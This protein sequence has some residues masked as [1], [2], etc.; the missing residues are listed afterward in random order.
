MRK[1]HEVRNGCIQKKW[2]CVLCHQM[3]LCVNKFFASGLPA[4]PVLVPVPILS[5]RGS[6]RKILMPGYKIRHPNTFCTVPKVD[7]RYI[8]NI[9]PV[10]L[11][12]E[13][14]K[15]DHNCNRKNQVFLH[16]EI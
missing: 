13:R 1:D 7:C 14:K 8:K 9:P 11:Y 3:T 5:F 2:Y 6:V 12:F 4:K 15:K 16:S 10:L